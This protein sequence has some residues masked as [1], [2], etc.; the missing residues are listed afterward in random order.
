MTLIRVITGVWLGEKVEDI[1]RV[2]YAHN[3]WW[4]TGKVP[5]QLSPNFRRRDFYK[6]RDQMSSNEITGIVGA[7][8][9]GKTTLM[10]QLVEDLLTKVDPKNILYLKVDDPFLSPTTDALRNIF[11]IYAINILSQPLESVQDTVY[12]MLDEIQA[13]EDWELFLKR[14]YD[15]GYKMKFIV[16]GSSSLEIMQRGAESLVGRF[17]PQI[18]CPMKFLE[19]IRYE[20]KEVDTDRRYDHINWK[21][22]ESFLKGIQ[23]NN[24]ET[25]FNAFQWASIQLAAERDEIRIKLDD[26]LIRGGYPAVVSIN[27]YYKSTEILRDYLYLTIYKDIVKIFSI[28]DPKTFESLFT[29]LASECCN[30]HNYS[31]LAND[32]GVKRDTIKDYLFYLTHSYLINETKYYSKNIRK[33][34][35]NN[36]KIYIN[37]N[38]L[39]NS[40]LGLIDQETLTDPL[41]KGK[42][43]ENIVADHCRRMKF[44]LGQSYDSDIFYW[45]NKKGQEVDIIVELLGKPIPIEV[46]YR[47]E[48]KKSD[49]SGMHEFIEQYETPFN[50]VITQHTLSLKD[51][52]INIPLW[53]FLLLC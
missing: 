13:V 14:W 30:K 47:R 2:L 42:L 49:L 9:V 11:D 40:V 53:L 19:V 44:S 5:K 6:L 26:Y 34:A 17:H 33:Q 38:G 36:K 41:Q 18:V 1:V 46:K 20:N 12:I 24:P 43:V 32:L 3:P 31:N 25:V 23:D 7:R 22:R 8:R 15:L 16:S 10:Y 28:R 52:Y 51:D 45:N 27:D 4:R 35:R 48:I 37:D 21:I 50:L 39:R 29:V